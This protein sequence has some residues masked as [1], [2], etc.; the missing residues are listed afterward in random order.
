MPIARS[1]AALLL[2]I[3]VLALGSPPAAPTTTI[4]VRLLVGQV[5]RTAAATPAPRTS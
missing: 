2:V 4:I 3:A 5:D 1:L